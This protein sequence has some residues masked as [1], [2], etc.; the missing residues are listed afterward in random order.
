MNSLKN[1]SE[2][3]KEI[4]SLKKQ[5]HDFERIK[6]QHKKS[7]NLLIK[8]EKKYRDL[9][10]KSE[11]AILIIKNGKFVDCNQATVKMLKYSSK[12]EFDH[13]ICVRGSTWGISDFTD[14]L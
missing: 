10:E 14:N 5:V 4:E 13:V 6:K 1:K 11:D 7:E 9:F 12:E 3:I 8:S 2:L